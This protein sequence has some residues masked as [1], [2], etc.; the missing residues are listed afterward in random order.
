MMS[1]LD[2]A[3]GLVAR[4]EKDNAIAMLAA[5]LMRNRDDVEAWLLLGET[6]D[7]P[8]RKRDCYNQVL[9]LSPHGIQAATRLQELEEPS[10]PTRPSVSS[11]NVEASVRNTLSEEAKPRQNRALK[12][13][14]PS[15]VDDSRNG[16]EI[17]V[18]VIGGI[19]VFLFMVYVISSPHPS[20]G[21]SNILYLGLV[22]LS[23][24]AGIIILTVSSKNRG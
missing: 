3:R 16:M 24:V 15:P 8:A 12:R 18:Y 22:F 17:I 11:V 4:G 14:F 13:D 6:I 10:A 23:L 20:S 5:M 2:Q 1:D 9:R 21:D 7:D 19:A